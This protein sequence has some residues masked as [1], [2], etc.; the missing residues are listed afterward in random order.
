MVA[1]PQATV[2][3]SKMNVLYVGVPNPMEISAPGVPADEI[4]PSAAGISFRP[5]TKKGT[6][7]A[8][9]TIENP[10]GTEIVV[11]KKDGT[12]LGGSIFRVKRLPDPVASILGQKEGLVTK[13][14]LSAA[15][16]L[17]AEMENFDF[18]TKVDVYDPWVDSKEVKHEYGITLTDK[19]NK[20]SAITAPRMAS[21]KNSSRSL[22]MRKP[23]S[24][25]SP[26][27]AGV[28]ASR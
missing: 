18:D 28:R 5:D 6:F 7:I 19:L 14:K 15:S 16:F 25:S 3:A 23:L 4:T 27:P 11:K 17:K 12:K 26:N 21:P 20:Y 24:V 13:G 9:A 8:T 22:D 10:K 1:E 2:A